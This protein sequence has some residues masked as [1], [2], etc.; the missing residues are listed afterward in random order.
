MPRRG[1]EDGQAVSAFSLLELIAVAA[2]RL[3]AAERDLFD[4]LF[5]EGVDKEEAR[6]RRG[7][8]QEQFCRLHDSMMRSLCGVAQGGAAA[9]GGDA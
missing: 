5:A 1:A 7:L 2:S 6:A 4:E 3:P 8:S 9:A